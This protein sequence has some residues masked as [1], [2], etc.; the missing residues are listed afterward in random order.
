MEVGI[1]AKLHGELVPG[2]RELLIVFNR[3]IRT[4]RTQIRI[5]AKSTQELPLKCVL[6]FEELCNSMTV[7]V[8]FYG[9]LFSHCSGKIERD[10]KRRIKRHR[11]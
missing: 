7:F 1:A 11:L 6:L 5:L 10:E 4:S 3:S 8:T 2:N 9:T